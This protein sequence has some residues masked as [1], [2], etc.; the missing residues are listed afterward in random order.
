MELAKR[1][2][3]LVVDDQPEYFSQLAEC[4]ELCAYSFRIECRYADS[5]QAMTDLLTNW[6]PTVVVLDVHASF[7]PGFELLNRLQGKAIPVVVTS[8]NHSKEIERSVMERGAA[9]Y[10]QKSDDP[11]EIERA[12]YTLAG[13]SFN[14]NEPN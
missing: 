11:E 14:L 12:L 5:E 3:L 13:Y 6:R 4:A 8:S 1:V 10:L 2:R 7:A 9:A